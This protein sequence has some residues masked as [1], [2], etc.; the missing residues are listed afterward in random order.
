MRWSQCPSLTGSRVWNGSATMSLVTYCTDDSCY[1]C[2]S[3]C[4][5]AVLCLN[6]WR[7]CLPPS[8][9]Q[10]P[11]ISRPT[12]F[13]PLPLPRTKTCQY[14]SPF[15]L[16]KML[17]CALTSP[18]NGRCS[19]IQRYA[20]ASLA[21]GFGL[22]YAYR[23]FNLPYLILQRQQLKKRLEIN[24]VDISATKDELTITGIGT[25]EQD[26]NQFVEHLKSKRGKKKKAQSAADAE[27]ATRYSPPPKQNASGG[28]GPVSP[29]GSSD[30]GSAATSPVESAP[31]GKKKSGGF[32]SRSSSSSASSKK[33]GSAPAVRG[34]NLCCCVVCFFKF[35][36]GF[37]QEIALYLIG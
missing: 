17:T 10:V 23:F 6:D 34:S 33:G 4:T 27:E 24:A 31:G 11:G 9:L 1:N 28:I 37:Y 5:Y 26:Y 35:M 29:T 20:E 30:A 19:G 18:L 36:S 16:I 8:I 2:A 14:F 3:Y 12:P 32:F 15:F 22:M 13:T 7:A 25:R 21:N